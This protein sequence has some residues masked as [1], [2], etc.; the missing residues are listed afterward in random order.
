MKN[1]WTVANAA[2]AILWVALAITNTVGGN[3]WYEGVL[4]VALASLNG[5]AAIKNAERM[6]TR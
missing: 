1:F 3:F 2:L 6:P 5:A 4:Y